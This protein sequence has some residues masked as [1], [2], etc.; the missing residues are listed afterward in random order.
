MIKRKRK[1]FCYFIARLL[2]FRV[3]WF[4]STLILKQ[5]QEFVGTHT[6]VIFCLQNKQFFQTTFYYMMKERRF[7]LFCE[8]IE[9]FIKSIVYSYCYFF[10]FNSNIYVCIQLWILWISSQFSF[11]EYLAISA[12]SWANCPLLILASK[13]LSVF[14]NITSDISA[15]FCFYLSLLSCV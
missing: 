6:A 9:V 4:R 1:I 11:C 15:A 13:K 12:T 14:S 8:S 10:L 7:C 3:F 5:D 2:F